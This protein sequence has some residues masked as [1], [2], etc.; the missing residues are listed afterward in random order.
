[1]VGVAVKACGALHLAQVHHEYSDSGSAALHYHAR[2]TALL[3]YQLPTKTRTKQR[4]EMCAVITTINIVYEMMSGTELTKHITTACA[5]L[6]ECNWNALSSGLA[7][8]CFWFNVGM[9]ALNGVMCNSSVAW[10]PDRWKYDPDE[11]SLKGSPIPE[12]WMHKM[13][14]A[15]ASA[16]THYN[17]KPGTPSSGYIRSQRNL[18]RWW[19]WCRDFTPRTMQ[20]LAS[21]DSGLQHKSSSF[22]NPG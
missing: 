19:K 1:M 10:D 4:T 16:V 12:A 13:V 15:F 20:P 5:L 18:T 9:D 17:T 8:A 11:G 22:S 21:L 6:Q 7:R 3:Q 2:T 14:F